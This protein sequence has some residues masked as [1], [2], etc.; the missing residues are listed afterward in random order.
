VGPQGAG[1]QGRAVTVMSAA[2][3]VVA[4]CQPSAVQCSAVPACQRVASVSLQPAGAP[5]QRPTYP[6]R[7]C[8]AARL[9]IPGTVI[10]C[11]TVVCFPAVQR[12][13]YEELWLGSAWEM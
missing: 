8:A 10:P 1:R 6:E 13:S 5:L 4:T 9:R 11:G 3:L 12:L 2:S 7:E